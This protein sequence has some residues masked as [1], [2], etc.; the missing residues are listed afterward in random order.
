MNVNFSTR[1]GC[2]GGGDYALSSRVRKNPGISTLYFTCAMA[3]ICTADAATALHARHR[4][5]CISP[6]LTYYTSL[7]E[8]VQTNQKQLPRVIRQ[9]ITDNA[10][11]SI[12]HSTVQLSWQTNC[13]SK[14]LAAHYVSDGE[15]TKHKP[16]LCCSRS[17][18]SHWLTEMV[19]G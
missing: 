1:S 12:W 6:S 3:F 10:H 8:C 4:S 2:V 19:N 14:G 13:R 5:A 7:S 16:W 11:C 15:R 18:A 17:H 9:S